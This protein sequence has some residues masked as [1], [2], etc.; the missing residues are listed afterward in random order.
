M[1]AI[2]VAAVVVAEMVE[3][4]AFQPPEVV[5]AEAAELLPFEAPLMTETIEVSKA[6]A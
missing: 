6:E 3:A 4:L 5:E 1:T 2:A